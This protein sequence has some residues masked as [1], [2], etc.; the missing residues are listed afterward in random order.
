MCANPSLITKIHLEKLNYVYRGPIRSSHITLE[1]GF[2]IL[3]ERVSTQGN[4]IKLQIVPAE[5]QNIV[6]IAFHANP[7]GGHLGLYQ[8]LHKIRLR[9]F[10]PGMW[11]YIK[12]LIEA[13]PVCRLA[14]PSIQ[15][16][17]VLDADVC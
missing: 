4:F 3:K 16:S 11:F 8:T 17:K 7:I 2:L 1:D 10:W 13:C 5:L 9:Y 12:K 15:K 14:N 6:F